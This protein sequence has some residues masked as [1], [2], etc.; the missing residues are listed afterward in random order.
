[1]SA[2]AKPN[3]KMGLWQKSKLW[4]REDVYNNI[5]WDKECLAEAC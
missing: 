3:R 5:I 4:A 1:L 2:E